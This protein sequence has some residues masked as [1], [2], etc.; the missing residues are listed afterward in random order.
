MTKKAAAFLE[1]IIRIQDEKSGLVE[2]KRSR[3]EVVRR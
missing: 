3:F 2:P 1:L